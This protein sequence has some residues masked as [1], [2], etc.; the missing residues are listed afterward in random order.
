MKKSTACKNRD[1]SLR[2]AVYCADPIKR[3]NYFFGRLLA[4]ND[5]AAEQ[6]YHRE[7][8]RRHN[9]HC[10]G[11]GVVSGLKVFTTNE[12]AGWTVFIEPGVA[13][14]PTGNEIQLCTTARFLLP[15]SQTALQVGIRFSERLCDPVPAV[16]DAESLGSQP[17]RVEEGSGGDI[18]SSFK[19]GR[20]AGES[21]RAR[22]F[23]GFSAAGASRT[24]GMCME[25]E[26]EI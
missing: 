11:F 6:N 21:Q 2:Q 25:G 9:R 18:E 17:S 5:L 8:Q 10:H 23:P 4:A 7:K 1:S 14:D 12:K 3:P 20:A 15:E 13:I 16:S 22:R 19:A 26:P 24:N